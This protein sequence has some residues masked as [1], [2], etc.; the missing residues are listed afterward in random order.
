[1]VKVL[2]IIGNNESDY[3]IKNEKDK[4]FVDRIIGGSMLHKSG[5]FETIIHEINND[6]EI[7]KKYIHAA[8][9][10]RFIYNLEYISGRNVVIRANAPYVNIHGIED[11]DLKVVFV[12]HNDYIT[13]GKPKFVDISVTCN[14]S[15]YTSIEL[16]KW[17]YSVDNI[18]ELV[19]KFENF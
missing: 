5:M 10:Q 18:T 15:V 11:I 14:N 8:V 12:Q 17:L 13:I 6:N 16:N 7:L 4:K 1:M 9:L 3:S 2:M 19:T